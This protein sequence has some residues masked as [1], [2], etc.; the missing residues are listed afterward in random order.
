LDNPEFYFREA[1][2]Y[3]H[4]PPTS[5]PSGELSCEWP[6]LAKFAESRMKMVRFRL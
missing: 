3:E 5:E 2:E 6:Y 1:G 4:G